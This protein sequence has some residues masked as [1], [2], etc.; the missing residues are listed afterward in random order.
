LAFI[1][2]VIPVA[3]SM[4]VGYYYRTHTH[5]VASEES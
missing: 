1:I 2:R 3:K 4:I 5:S